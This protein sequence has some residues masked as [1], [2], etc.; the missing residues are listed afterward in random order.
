MRTNAHSEELRE[1]DQ[2]LE[3]FYSDHS[4]FYNVHSTE[5]DSKYFVFKEHGKIKAG[6]RARPV[7]WE[8]VE[9]PDKFMSAVFT[10]SKYLPII[11]KII[12]P[13]S[14][15]FIAID[16]VWFTESYSH[17]LF[18]MIHHALYETDHHLAFFWGDSDSEVSK[19]INDPKKAGVF[20]KIQKPVSAHLMIRNLDSDS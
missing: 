6:L 13:S 3:A 15:E 11:R 17:S 18:P 8:I 2:H 14:L 20:S 12:Q 5:Q 7:S 19:I 16:K 10:F 1:F 4:L 9:L